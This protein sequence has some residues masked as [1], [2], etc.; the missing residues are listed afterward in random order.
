MAYYEPRGLRARS[1]PEPECEGHGRELYEKLEFLGAKIFPINIQRIFSRVPIDRAYQPNS[2]NAREGIYPVR[3]ICTRLGTK[4][5]DWL[6]MT[7]R[8]LTPPKR[9]LSRLCGCLR[10]A[11]KRASP[12]K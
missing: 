8:R 5:V 10:E 6:G 1:L 11:T 12:N 4:K 9:P 2:P 3:P 7:H